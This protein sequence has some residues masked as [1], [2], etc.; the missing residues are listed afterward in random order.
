VPLSVNTSGEQRVTLD[1]AEGTHDS[2][3]PA[4]MVMVGQYAESTV[5]TAV[6]DG[7]AVR[8]N[9]D[10]LGRQ[11]IAGFDQ[12][13]NVIA[14]EEQSPALAQ[15]SGPHTMTQLTAAATQ[16]EAVNIRNYKHISA[17]VTTANVAAAG[18]AVHVQ[19]QASHDGT[20]YFSLAPKDNTVAN[21]TISGA[22]VQIDA[23]MVVG[24]LFENVAAEY[25]RV[26]FT[27]EDGGATDAT[28]DVTIMAGN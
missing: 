16:T 22:D 25:F 12:P 8:P 21:V 13:A 20:N 6:A 3:A 10:T 11:R 18:D 24:L 1:S 17:A 28:V 4:R 19:G 14:V 23:S 2:A 26:E 15:K 7:D 5:P 27:T 9:Y